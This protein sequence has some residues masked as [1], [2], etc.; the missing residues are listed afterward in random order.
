MGLLHAAIDAALA[1]RAEGDVQPEQI[2][3]IEIDM[4]LAAYEHGGW[5]A[6]RPLEPIGA[7][8]NVAYAV[9]A[10][11]L[12]GQVLIE[13]FAAIRIN[14]DDVWHLI[15]RT[16]TRHQKTYDDLPVEQRLTTRVAVTLADGSVREKTVAH[17]RGT[18]DRLLTNTDIVE[19]YRELTRSV[20]TAQRQAAI[21][22]TVLDLENL[23]DITDLTNLLT[24]TVRAAIG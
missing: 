23:T 9:A 16:V 15:E 24:S 10:A 2:E 12:D 19:K 17:P 13:Q 5:Q 22:A 20:I 21:E 11:L 4:P 18:A 6:Q 7:Q 14:R 1:L 3:R 8:M